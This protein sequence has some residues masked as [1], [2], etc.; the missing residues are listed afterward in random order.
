MIPQD[1]VLMDGTVRYNLDP[2][3]EFSD[4]QIQKVL[5]AGDGRNWQAIFG[6]I[7]G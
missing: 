6:A 5:A 4:A 2:F 7:L 1:P 3:Y